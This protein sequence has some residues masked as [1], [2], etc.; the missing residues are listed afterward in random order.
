M[1]IKID[2]K[3]IETQV[4]QLAKDILK[5]Y[6]KQALTDLN[7][8][9][10]GVQIKLN[11]WLLAL[12]NGEIDQEEFDDLVLGEKDLVELRALK[13]FGLGQV[14]LDTFTDGLLKIIITVAKT[15]I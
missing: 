6:T 13:L 2:W 14:A 15:A 11:K 9:R 8:Y 7:Q 10:S 3:T 5:G 4:A 12:K 1:K